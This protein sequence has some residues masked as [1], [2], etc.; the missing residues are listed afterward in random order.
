M[1]ILVTNDDG[2]Y[3]KGIEVL[4]EI[5]KE[6]HEVHVVAPETEQSAVGHAITF[7]D[8]LR[9]RPIK[10]NGVFF[11]YAVNGTPA[12]CVKLAVRELMAE[13]PDMVISGINMGAN[14]GENVIY[15]GTVSAATEA[16]MLGFPSMAVSIDA[17]P[18]TDY[19]A[20]RQYLPLIV[21]KLKTRPL[22]PGISLNVNIP[23]LPA[24]EVRGIRI[25]RQGHLRYKERYDRRVDP[26]NRVYY[27]LCSQTIEH[28][29]DPN[30]D[31]RALAEGYITITPIH[32]DL[33]HYQT[34]EMLKKQDWETTFEVA[35][36]RK[37]SVSSR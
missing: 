34:Y 23:H 7:L 30:S 29:G 37:M 18:A 32:Y 15:S 25:T 19:S 4:C 8:P 14:V 3:A 31:S 10:R 27:W 22:P 24:S 33:T 9:V 12:D 11:G 21:E 35:H 28:D 1:K 6:D 17:Y 26:R 5:L 13:P 2:I 36:G 16:A 20:A